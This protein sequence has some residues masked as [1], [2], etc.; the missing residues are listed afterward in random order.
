ML[1]PRIHYLADEQMT[2]DDEV[3]FKQLGGRIAAM[4]K[5]LGMTQTQL[6]EILGVSQQHMA[7]FE[8]GRRKVSA[9]AIPI[10]AKLFG[11]STDELMGMEEAPAKR[12]RASKLQR[13]MELVS[14]LPKSKQHLVTEML[15]AIIQQQAS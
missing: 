8:V 14:R 2:K 13:Q 1:M 11:M 3:F 7:S 10:L 5:K 4:R 9:S 6:A 12:G 15:E